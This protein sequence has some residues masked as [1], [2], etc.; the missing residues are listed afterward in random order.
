[1]Q[2][3]LEVDDVHVRFGREADSVPVLNGASL[4]LQPG[5]SLG[6]VGESGAGKTVLVRTI[7]NLLRPP[8]EVRRGR[9]IFE[10]EDLLKKN[11]EELGRIRGKKIALTSP[12]PRKQLNPLVRVGDQIANAVRAHSDMSGKAALDRAVELLTAVGLPDP[13][14]RVRSYPHELSGGMCQRVVIAMALAHSPKVLLADE[15][16]AGLDVTISRQILDLMHDLIREFGSSLILV[17][18]DLGVV[19]HYCQR[20]AVM[21]AGQIVEIG[22][23]SAFYS[24][25][26]HPYSRHLLRA[27]AAARDDRRGDTSPAGA[28]GVFNEMGCVYAPRCPVSLPICHQER[29]ALGPV[30]DSHAAQCHR[31]VEV[32]RGEVQT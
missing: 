12:E 27:V 8:W 23:T 11:E 19:A 2:P 31:K 20:V 32:S 24:A 1:M 13:R 29:P 6:I 14:L 18:R 25:A 28:R 4:T 22:E 15:P 17:T 16:T 10:G 9:V 7:L 30:T 26:A 21:Y 3:L 5:E